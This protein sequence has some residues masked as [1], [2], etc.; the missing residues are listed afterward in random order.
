MRFPKFVAYFLLAIP[1]LTAQIAQQIRPE[2]AI[3]PT[4]PRAAALNVTPT[5]TPTGFGITPTAAPGSVF[6]V[7]NPGLPGI[8]TYNAGQPMTTATSP[9][10]KTLLVLT[11]GYNLLNDA[12]GAN[13]TAAGNE[14]VFIYDISANKLVQLGAVPLPAAYAGIVW[15][16]SGKEFYVSGGPGDL[17]FVITA[18]ASGFGLGG[19][20]AMGHPNTT[21][22]GSGLGIGYPSIVAGMAVNARGDRLLVANL[23]NDSVTLVDIPNRKVITELDLRPGVS[24]PSKVGVAGGEY[25]FWV[26]VKGND[27]AYVSS[28]RDR[29]IDVL[30]ITGDKPT[31]SARIPVQGNPNKMILDKL[32]QR[33]IVA[34]DN[35]DAAVVVDTNR[36]VVLDTIFTTAPAPP[37]VSASNFLKGSNPNALALSPDE[38]TLYVTNGA[39]NS[40]AVIAL[41]TFVSPSYTYG[42]IPTGWYP[43]AIALS[44]DGSAMFVANA[45]N[46]PGPNPLNCKSAIGVNGGVPGCNAANQYVWQL[47]KGGML[48]IPVPADL[49]SLDSLTA[50]VEQNN[51]FAPAANHDANLAIMAQVRAKIKHVIYIIKENRTYDQILGDLPKGN[52]NPAITVF[53]NAYTPNQHQIANQFVT[54]DN[55]YDSGEVS[56]VGWNWS[57]SARATDYVE[58][59]VPPSYANRFGPVFYE[60]EGTNR[61]TNLS[62]PDLATRQKY[63]PIIPLLNDPNLLPGTVDVAAPDSSEGDAGAGYLWDGALRHGLSIRNYGCFIDLIRYELPAP[64][65]AV[66]IP[67]STTPFASGVVQAIPS[68][69]SLAPYTDQYFRGFDNTWPDFYRYQEWAREFDGYVAAG[70]LP[71][72]SMVR[73]MHDHTGNFDTAQ[74]GVNTPEAQIADNDYAVGLLLEHLAKSPYAANTLVFVIEDDAQDGPDHVDAHRSTAYVAGPYVKQNALVSTRYNTVNFLRTI[75]DVLGIP[76]YGLSDGTAEPMADI[77][78]MAQ[79]SWNYTSLV[80]GILRTAT[81]LPLPVKTSS[82]SVPDTKKNLLA[83]KPRHSAQWWAKKMKGQDFDKEDDLDTVSYNQVLWRGMMG[84]KPY[85]VVRDGADLRENRANLLQGQQ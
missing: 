3:R 53:G 31:V 55:F 43:Q 13:L 10:G 85:P 82:N 35:A 84:R 72:L 38:K 78:D 41:N 69:A 19:T 27:K 45:K 79:T 25:P 9:D 47:E 66:N 83:S 16:P 51:N 67:P 59:T 70:N 74:F 52:G 4:G 39:T 81:T 30:T 33:L 68:K 80:P 17:V 21:G 49:P 37:Y 29:E 60:Y 8:M 12:S 32:Q 11:S 61:N 44:A 26:A 42:L 34:E 73:L 15:N 22:F 1:A 6:T 63:L 54:L 48:T 2:P 58:K 14:Y 57:T 76:Y 23:M 24:D 71:S 28:M 40:V 56:G 75:K 20:I 18:T 62:V 5:M 50:Q 36:D 64:F 65:T 46:V 7:M 77:F